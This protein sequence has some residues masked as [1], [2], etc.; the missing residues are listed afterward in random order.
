MPV[1]QLP[2]QRLHSCGLFM[3]RDSSKLTFFWLQTFSSYWGACPW[4]LG[5]LAVIL[6]Q[7]QHLPGY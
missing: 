7:G 6:T 4:Y 3:Y 1:S 5:A 2:R